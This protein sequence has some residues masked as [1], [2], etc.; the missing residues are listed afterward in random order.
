MGSCMAEGKSIGDVS[1]SSG[2]ETVEPD[3][4]SGRRRTAP[5][6]LKSLGTDALI[7]FMNSSQALKGL[8]NLW[9]YCD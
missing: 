9:M 4:P 1:F 5:G 8:V 6:Q 2:R 3:S 7:A